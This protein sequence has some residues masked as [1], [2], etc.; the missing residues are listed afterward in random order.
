MDIFKFHNPTSPMQMEQGEI[1]NGFKS[2]MWIERYRDAGEFTLVASIDSGVR[3][4]LPLGS[5]ISHVDTKEIMIVENHEISD[6]RGKETDIKITGRGFESFLE[7]R[8]ISSN[9]YFPNNG[10]T[11]DYTITANYTWYQAQFLLQDH[12]IPSYLLDPNDGLPFLDIINEVTGSAD[13]VERSVQRGENLYSSLLSLL[14][15]NNLGIK[16]L[17][18]G[19]YGGNTSLLIHTGVDRSA[20]IVYSY[21][22]GEIESADYLWS[23]KK[24][25]NSALVS[26]KWVE[27][28]VD[29]PGKVQYD[30]RMMYVNASDIDDIFTAPPETTDLITVIG[31][32]EQRGFSALAA[33]KE[34]VLVKAEVSKENTKAIYR[35]DFDVG[36]LITVNGDYNQ[37]SKM[38]VNEFVEIED[39]TG[40]SAYPTLTLDQ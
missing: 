10:G 35:R 29:D 9:R 30:R 31:K 37:A 15:I 7:N 24:L 39:G 22:T 40:S 8:I 23:M 26:G 32:M 16:I 19:I 6:N 12:V 20:S 36:D 4:K 3:E 11:I 18:P 2:K 34:L 27:V 13:F 1:V 33:Q 5:F 14:A 38:R 25:K 17:R 28:R 21:D